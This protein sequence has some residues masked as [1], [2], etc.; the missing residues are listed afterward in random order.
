MHRS[1]GAVRLAGIRA[2]VEQTLPPVEVQQKKPKPAKAVKKPVA[3][4]AEA[5]TPITPNRRFRQHL[6]AA[7]P[8]AAKPSPIR[9]RHQ[10][11][12]PTA[13]Q[14][15]R[16]QPCPEWRRFE[17]ARHPWH[18][19]RAGKDRSRRHAHHRGLPQPYEPGA[20]VYRTRRRSAQVKVY[21]GITPVSAGGDSI[22]GTILVESA[23]PRFARRAMAIT[24]GTVSVFGRSN[25]NGLSTS[26]S[27]SMATS[28]VNI[29][30]TGAWAK[31]GDYKDG[32]AIPL[33][34]RST[35]A[36]PQAVGGRARQRQ[37]AHH[38]RRLSAYPVRG[39]P[40]RI[41]GHGQQ[42]RMVRRTRHYT[43][44][45]STGASSTCAPTSRTRAT[46]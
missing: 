14:Y 41:Y 16:R 45:G 26:G 39:L 10:R 15:A 46:R 20:V 8:S 11:H 28:N 36:K 19:G 35:N 42:Q 7:L 38:R 4:P 29:T 43:A 12:G 1:R 40:Q 33:M 27:V 5:A 13:R 21:A 2:V 30:Y 32:K 31:S 23:G 34:P 24:Y 6:P 3:A 44:G 22:G 17:L 37:S 18:G 25:G 9:S